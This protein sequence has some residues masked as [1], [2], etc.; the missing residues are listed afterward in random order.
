MQHRHTCVSG[1]YLI[2]R[3]SPCHENCPVVKLHQPFCTRILFEPHHI[4]EYVVLI[5]CLEIRCA[6]RAELI[7]E[8]R[9]ITRRNGR[10]GQNCIFGW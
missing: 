6:F 1:S 3:Q 4:L 7:D 10:V 9:E 2:Q 8:E 5:R